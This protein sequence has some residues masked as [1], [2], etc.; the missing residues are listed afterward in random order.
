MILQ[1]LVKHYEDLV[2]KGL[3][4]SSGWS[5]QK[6]SYQ[7]EI[8]ASGELL[9]VS[10]LGDI[11]LKGTKTVHKPLLTDVPAPVKRAVNI[12]PNFLCDH[13][14]Y[15]LTARGNRN[16]LPIASKPAVHFTRRSLQ[17]QNPM[18]QKP[19][20][21]F[22]QTGNLKKPRSILRFQINGKNSLQEGI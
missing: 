6:V 8:D 16:G 14:G 5:K 19:F 12:A 3:I 7:L 20:L 21:H 22:L 2:E 15:M 17:K 4:A 18:Q 11:E 9:Q 1:A 13:S 10:L